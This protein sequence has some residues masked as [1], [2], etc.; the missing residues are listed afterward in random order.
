M[1]PDA[2]TKWA[3][4]DPGA[5]SH[6]VGLVKDLVGPSTAVMAIVKANGYG[7]GAVQVAQAALAG[8]AT[9]LGVSS[10]A[11]GVELRQAGITAPILNMGYTPPAALSTAINE[12]LSI[13][14]Y[15][16]ASLEA[17]QRT[18]STAAVQVKVDTGMHRLGAPADDAVRLVRELRRSPNLRLEGFWTHF[19]SAEADPDFTQQ[20]LGAYLEARAQIQKEGARGFIS[21]AANS[22]G[23]LRFPAA[24][25]DMVRAGLIIY[26]VRPVPEWRDL[27][28]LRPALSWHAMVTNL[29]LVAAG[30][31]VGYGRRFTAAQ[32]TKIATLAVGYA[33]GLHRRLS[34]RGSAIVRGR[35]VPIVG[36]ISM[37]QATV[38]V[39]AV[40]GVEIG[41]IACLIGT[42]GG[43]SRQAD[44]MA[45]AAETISYD[46]LCAISAR[47]PRRYRGL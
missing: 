5:I 47:V 34:N 15:D 20:Q 8:G 3:D 43:A 46:V 22:A 27:P 14:L 12:K 10:V 4:V 16:Q 23:L 19:A 13:T 6:N 37:D 21:H 18:G 9:W 32:P 33:D 7:H 25:L 30:G 39:T 31:T 11:E 17:L 26:G 40:P 2:A 35:I 28:A 44:D 42:D 38:D 45:K 29:Q 41:D 1:T 36:T 24:R